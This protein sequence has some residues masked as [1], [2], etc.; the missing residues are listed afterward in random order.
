MKMVENNMD[1]ISALNF[2]PNSRE[3]NVRV[4]KGND[5]RVF[6]LWTSVTLETGI[7]DDFG[8]QD[9]KPGPVIQV[10]NEWCLDLILW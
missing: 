8:A 10:G 4:Q 9:Q 6:N 3:N 2:I 1:H 7:E 5:M